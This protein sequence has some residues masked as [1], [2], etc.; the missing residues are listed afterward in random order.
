[1]F[2]QEAGFLMFNRI[3]ILFTIIRL[4]ECRYSNSHS[5]RHHSN[6]STRPR[7]SRH[8][9]NS[10]PTV[11]MFLY[12]LSKTHF[13]KFYAPLA[14]CAIVAHKTSERRQPNSQSTRHYRNSSTRPRQA[15]HNPN[16]HPTARYFLRP[17]RATNSNRNS[18]C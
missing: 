1:M 5:T 12:Q 15:R 3:N 11:R 18:M 17:G 4:S 2:C 10:Y 7:H 13:F 14:L 9:S 6:S 8:Y 16:T